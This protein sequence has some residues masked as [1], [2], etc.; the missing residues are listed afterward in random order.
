[1]PRKLTILGALTAL[2]LG[3]VGVMQDG[4][5]VHAGIQNFDADATICYGSEPVDGTFTCPGASGT[6]APT[7]SSAAQHTLIELPAGSRL[8]LP[9]VYT[10]TSFGFTP[11]PPGDEGNVT[12]AT[13]L[14]CNSGVEDILASGT[15][16]GDPAPDP[17]PP[18]TAADPWPDDDTW[19]PYPFIHQGVTPAGDDAYVTTIKPMPATFTPLSHDK[20]ELYT[21]WLNKTTPLFL[22]NLQ[23]GNPTP[24]NLVTEAVPSAY[25]GGSPNLRVS[26]T[27]LAGSPDNPPNSSFTLCLD[28][29]QNSVSANIQT[30]TPAAPGRYPRFTAFTS[31]VDERDGDVSRILDLNCVTVGAAPGV[32]ADGDCLTDGDPDDAAGADSDGDLV[33]DGIEKLFGTDETDPDTD[34]DGATD[35]D[36][37]FQFTNPH[38]TDTDGDGSLDRQDNG[39]DENGVTPAIDDTTADDNCPSDNATQTNSDA[40]PDNNGVTGDITNPSADQLG[41]A[42]DTDDDNDGIGDVAEA[43]L[44]IDAAPDFCVGPGAGGGNTPTSSTDDDTD[45]DLG[46]D[47]VECKY[48]AN[49]LDNA[50]TMPVQPADNLGN[51]T[52]GTADA[53]ET[54][55]R[56]GSINI[57]SGG[58]DNN[59]DGDASTNPVSDQDSDNDG[60]LDGAEVKQ[61]G[62]HPTNADSD[63][64]GCSDGREAASVNSDRNVTSTDLGQIAQRFG[65][66]DAAAEPEKVTYDYLRNENIQ[67]GDLGQVAQRFGNCAA[68]GGLTITR[69]ASGW[70]GIPAP[71]TPPLP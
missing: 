10:P 12:S 22:P 27:L 68:F 30:T 23:G 44:E 55:Y 69:G 11:N 53:Q 56:T 4:S 64:D 71:N 1:M 6:T 15:D 31:D 37:I 70:P 40:A 8:T 14:L 59:P 34:G 57:P 7:S 16:P 42:C 39:A 38:L 60:L 47:G 5:T 36:E 28:S 52:V 65:T 33:P 20:A 9:I 41:D 21:L 45:D 43:G 35:Y 67:S 48:T 49:P 25:T 13:D 29:P 66:Y 32:D 3:I 54:F 46:L 51:I 24:L 61:Y 19:I 50:S 2:V 18:P 58:Q 26:A 62:T 63:D 17:V